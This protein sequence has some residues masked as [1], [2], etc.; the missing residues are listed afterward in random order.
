MRRA[1]PKRSPSQRRATPRAISRSRSTRR[2][3]EPRARAAFVRRHAS[4]PPNAKPVSHC[5]SLYGRRR[6]RQTAKGAKTRL[7]FLC[8]RRSR[9]RTAP[10]RRPTPFHVRDV[11]L[12]NQR[13]AVG[14]GAVSPSRAPSP[15]SPLAIL[16]ALYVPISRY[17]AH[18]GYAGLAEVFFDPLLILFA[19][20]AE[21]RFRPR[22]ETLDRDFLAAVVTDL[23]LIHI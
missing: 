7:T 12:T 10:T 17:K 5:A 15:I 2:T 13:S 22:L 8:L 19:A 23:S 21:R 3:N 11:W 1:L 16:G 4:R 6:N 18:R 14:R 20:D 9:F